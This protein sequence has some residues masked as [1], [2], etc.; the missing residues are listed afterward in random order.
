MGISYVQY[1]RL[2][3]ETDGANAIISEGSFAF[4]V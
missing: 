4:L 2:R 1:A 3:G